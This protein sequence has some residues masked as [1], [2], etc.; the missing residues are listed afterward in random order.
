MQAVFSEETAPKRSYRVIL[1]DGRLRWA[2]DDAVADR[3][4]DASLRRRMVARAISLLPVE[5]QL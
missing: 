5:S 1:R 3:E 4:P 2:G